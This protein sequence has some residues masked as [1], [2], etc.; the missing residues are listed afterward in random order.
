MRIREYRNL[1]KSG[2][3]PHWTGAL[4][5][6][7]AG[8]CENIPPLAL[9]CESTVKTH[10]YNENMW[11]FAPTVKATVKTFG[12]LQTYLPTLFTTALSIHH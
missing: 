2:K 6:D 11:V 3:M 10:I 12:P 7:V 5:F 9:Y 1:P 4:L 8:Y